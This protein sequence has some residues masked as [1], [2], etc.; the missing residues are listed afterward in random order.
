MIDNSN[1]TNLEIVIS[2]TTDRTNV[3]LGSVSLSALGRDY[4]IDV[5]NSSHV[6]NTEGNMVINC[7]LETDFEELVSLFGSDSKFDLLESDL[8]DD[9]LKAEVFVGG[10]Q[11]NIVSMK[12]YVS[13]NGFDK[14]INCIQD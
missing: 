13:V 7:E 6:I 5:S 9:D 10:E 14:T 12:L 3:D 4:K 11:F 1:I 8:L 2:G